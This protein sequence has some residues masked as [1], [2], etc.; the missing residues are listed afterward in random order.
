MLSL[1]NDLSVDAAMQ[2]CSMCI[3]ILC[4]KKSNFCYVFHRLVLMSG[5]LVVGQ[6]KT[7]AETLLLARTH[8]AYFRPMGQVVH[9][10]GRLGVDRVGVK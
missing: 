1:Y 10:L 7:H 5:L 3:N 9:C 6:S 8:K 2:F 4:E